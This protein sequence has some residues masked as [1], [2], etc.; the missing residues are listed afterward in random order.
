[1]YR[2]YKLIRAGGCAAVLALLLPGGATAEEVCE[3]CFSLP[4][5][6][7][8]GTSTGEVEGENFKFMATQ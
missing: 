2:L 1:M 3:P 5:F 8:S 7:L 4:Y 6:T